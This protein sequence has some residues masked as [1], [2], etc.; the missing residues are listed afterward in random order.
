[1]AELSVKKGSRIRILD[2]SKKYM[3]MN[4]KSELLTEL[5]ALGFIPE[6]LKTSAR[7]IKR[8]K[9]EL[10]ATMTPFGPLMQE[11]DFFVGGETERF[12]VQN[13]LAML[14][15]AMRT[16][17]RY[18]KYV[19]E[20][21]VVHGVPS[22]N[23]PWSLVVYFDEVACGNPLG[24]GHKRKIQG[25]YW[26]VYQ[27][28]MRALS[29]ESCWFEIVAFQNREVKDFD[30]SMSQVVE[31][32]LLCFFDSNTHDLRTG[33][34]FDLKG[35]GMFMLVAILEMLIADIKA[36]VEAI[37]S[38]GVTGVLPCFLCER[39]VSYKAKER[40]ALKDN[41]SFVTLACF[42]P[43]K[44]GKRDDA[45]IKKVLQDLDVAY[46]T[47]GNDELKRKQTLT[48][49]KY[50]KRNFLLNH[51][52]AIKAAFVLV[53]DWMHLFFQ[54]GNWNREVWA[55]FKMAIRANLP[56]YFEC[57]VYI[58][59]WIFP[60]AGLGEIFTKEHYKKLQQQGSRLL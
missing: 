45:N 2:L 21:I 58:K 27:L 7:S 53:F 5:K 47:L 6:D 19:R 39:V 20:G 40:P 17:E 35:H 44:W 48:G 36:L 15:E 3:T 4:A 18:S 59:A 13:P 25:V 10:A 16:S 54:T 37:C 60:G 41:D 42:D 28:G 22:N 24:L 56:S 51:S 30:G 43:T 33:L 23:N 29:D 46:H 11:R 49:Y 52:L 9:E 32:V 55:L 14:Y 38:N 8:E 50:C 34:V 31:Q 1:M 26:S 12:P 57:A